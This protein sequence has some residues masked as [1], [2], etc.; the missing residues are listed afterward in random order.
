MID[1][2]NETGILVTPDQEKSFNRVG[3]DFLMRVSFK[4]GFG[5]IAGGLVVL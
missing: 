2:T 4:F 1:K 5:P 3:H